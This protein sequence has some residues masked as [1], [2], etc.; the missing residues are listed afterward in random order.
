MAE[1]SEKQ[2]G[3]ALATGPAAGSSRGDTAVEPSPEGN[4]A[5]VALEADEGETD[6]TAS[7]D[8]RISNYTS[9]LTSSVIDYPTEYGRRYHAFRS[10]S[11][12]LPNDDIESERLDMAHALITKVIGNKLYLAP[13]ESHK[14]HRILDIGTGTGIWAIEA[15]DMFPN[16]E[17]SSTLSLSNFQVPAILRFEKVIGNDLSAIQPT[18]VPPNVKFEIDDVE[19]PWVGKKYDYI[20]CRFMA[21]SIGDWPKLVKSIYDNL[22]PGGWAEFQDMS[23]EYYSDDGTYTP[24]HAT[25]EWNQTFVNTLKSIG[26]DPCPGPQLEGWV[27]GHGGFDNLSHQKFKVPIGPWA[28]HTHYKEIGLL[29]LAQILDGLEAFSMKLFCGVLGKTETE[30][31]VQLASVRNEL[32]SNSFHALY[33]IHV[34][35]GQKPL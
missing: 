18:W 33:D 15:G 14:L 17:V 5:E 11:Y 6:G 20:M 13:I 23:V 9:S 8:D 29:N 16:A 34:V 4:T 35:Y 32:K 31:L 25:H 7:I 1:V 22:N 30:V 10:G 2:K 21:A 28:K 26:R 24:Q 3:S 12:V 19:S 27:R